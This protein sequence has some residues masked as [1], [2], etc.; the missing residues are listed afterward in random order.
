MR[1]EWTEQ[2]TSPTTGSEQSQESEATTYRAGLLYLFD[3][4][5]APYASC[6][7]SFEP[8]IGTDEDL[9]P[10]V[11]TEAEVPNLKVLTSRA[12]STG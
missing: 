1:Q 7:T 2:V 8:V 10:F 3:N 12:P 11:P 6:A 9:N 4:G 5:L